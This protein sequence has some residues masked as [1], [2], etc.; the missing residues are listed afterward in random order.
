MSSPS[1]L[2]R[3][4]GPNDK[5]FILV[6]PAISAKCLLFQGNATGILFEMITLMK[7]VTLRAIIIQ[8]STIGS[9]KTLA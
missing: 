3:K 5:M 4:Q 6:Q 7:V 9:A 1:H 8:S 2:E